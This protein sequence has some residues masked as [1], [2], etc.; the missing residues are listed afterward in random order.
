[1]ENVHVFVNESSHLS[2]TELFGEFGNLQEHELRGISEFVPCHTEIH[3]GAFWRNSECAYDSQLFSILDEI[4]IGSWASDPVDKSK[5]TGFLR[6]RTLSGEGWLTAKMQLRRIQNVSFLHRI[7]GNPGRSNWI[8]VEYFPGF[9]SLQ[10]LQEIQHDLKEEHWIRKGSQTES[11]SCQCSTTSI[12]QERKW[13][14]LYFE[15][16]KGQGIREEI[17]ARTLNVSGSWT[18]QE[19]VWNS[20]SHT[21]KNGILQPLRWWNDSKIQVIHY[22]REKVLRS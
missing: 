20:F 16:G 15:F 18:R 21:L 6:F 2:W 7:A 22:S 8:R 10:I 19:V 12:G 14:N 17:L 4:S 1:M 5:S 13:W 9:S 11:S 3:I